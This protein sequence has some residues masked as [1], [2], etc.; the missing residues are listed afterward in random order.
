VKGSVT[1][2]QCTKKEEW[3]SSGKISK[4]GF[5]STTETDAC[6]GKGTCVADKTKGDKFFM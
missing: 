5:C 2:G 1:S 3:E 4:Y 6:C